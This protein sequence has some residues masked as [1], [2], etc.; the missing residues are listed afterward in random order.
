MATK[1]K[2]NRRNKNKSLDPRSTFLVKY[3]TLLSE[4]HTRKKVI[5]DYCGKF[6]IPY[7]HMEGYICKYT[8]SDKDVEVLNSYL[9]SYPVFDK[10]LGLC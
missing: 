8:L 9:D 1:R 4:L 6:G 7:Y 10:E 5:H 2:T 3:K